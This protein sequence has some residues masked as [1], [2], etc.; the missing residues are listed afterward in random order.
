MVRGGSKKW[1]PIF[2]GAEAEKIFEVVLEIAESLRSPPYGWKKVDGEVRN[3]G[4][5]KI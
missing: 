5:A 1:Q 3:K 2:V 4:Q